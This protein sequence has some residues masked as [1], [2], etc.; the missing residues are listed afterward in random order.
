MAAVL[1]G[2][3]VL[4]KAGADAFCRA[5]VLMGGEFG[6]IRICAVGLGRFPLRGVGGSGRMNREAR[7]CNREARYC[8]E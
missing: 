6:E 8:S 1:M 7:C 3:K 5:G 4:A 2:E